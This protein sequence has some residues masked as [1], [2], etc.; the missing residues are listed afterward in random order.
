MAS[1]SCTMRG[2]NCVRL[3]LLSGP[4]SILMCSR[5]VAAFSWAAK[6]VPLGCER[7]HDAVT[8]FVGAAKGDRQR[9][10]IFLDDATRDIFLLAPHLMIPG[11]VVAPSE[12]AT[13][14]IA[15][16]HRRFTIHTPA[17]DAWC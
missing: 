10:T 8:R 15:A 3:P 7:I 4:L 13:R 16:M 6:A 12:T 17:F 2:R 9:G 1:A 5:L 14:I 11:L